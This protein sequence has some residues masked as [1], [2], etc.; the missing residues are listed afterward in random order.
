MSSK[1]SDTQL[2]QHVEDELNWESSVN[3]ASVGV[4]VNDAIVTLSGHVANYA[5]KRAAEKA[6]L[7]IRGV[8]AL[9]NEMEVKFPSDSRHTDEDIA[10]AAASAL[11]WNV[12]VPKDK[13]KIKVSEG[14]ITLEGAVDWQYQRT[15][16]EWAV[17]SLM[18]VR[19]V[20][21]LVTVKSVPTHAE[22][23]SQIEAALKRNAKVEADHISVMVQG[24]K[25]ILSGAVPSMANRLAAE[26]AAWQAAGVTHVEN[27]LQVTSTSRS[28][29]VA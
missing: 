6:V 11:A 7:R 29:A 22:V 8:K 15:S 27:N 13:I 3:A 16:A 19:G 2:K 26:R 9:A 18:G 10:R 5:E 28:F 12:S 14:W 20:V 1:Y 23:R 24:N 17:E 4:T 21:N 25:V